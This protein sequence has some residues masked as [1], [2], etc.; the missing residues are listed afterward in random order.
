MPHTR[1]EILAIG[2]EIA[3]RIFHKKNN[4][5]VTIEGWAA[6]DKDGQ[7]Y[8]Y[9]DGDKPTRYETMYLTNGELF[10]IQESFF[11]NIKWSDEEPTKVKITI[12]I[13]N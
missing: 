13:N 2:D 1:K 4:H 11:Q 10:E 3:N 6:R 7:I 8:I 12:T 5:H 9:L